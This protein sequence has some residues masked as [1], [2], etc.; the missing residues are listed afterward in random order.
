[1]RGNTRSERRIGFKLG[2]RYLRSTEKVTKQKER[3][4]LANPFVFPLNT[5]ALMRARTQTKLLGEELRR[6]TF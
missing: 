4:I 1:M 2:P 5:Q 6:V 3:K